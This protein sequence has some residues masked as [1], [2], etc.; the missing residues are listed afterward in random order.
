MKRL[1]ALTIVLLATAGAFAGA[2][3]AELPSIL[4]E[5]AGKTFT[6]ES[7]EMT[8]ETASKRKVTCTSGTGEGIEETGKAAGTFHVHVSGCSTTV[9]GIKFKCSGLGESTGVILVL[10]KWAIVHGTS[11]V[12]VLDLNEP[13]H[14]ECAGGFALV[15]VTGSMLCP[16]KEPTKKAATHEGSCEQSE[17]KQKQTEYENDEGKKVTAELSCSENEG[18]AEGIGELGL[19]VT[20]TYNEEIAIME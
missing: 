6:G 9:A 10:G 17:G 3:H 16:I 8:F 1:T 20:V 19:R 12:M 4:P 11:G 5:T 2:A 14:F 18:T 15:T 13:T 7:G